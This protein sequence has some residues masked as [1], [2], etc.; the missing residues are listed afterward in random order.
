M[1]ALKQILNSLREKS[2][3]DKK[4]YGTSFEALC[5]DFFSYEPNFKAKF[6]EVLSY[7]E[8]AT[9]NN[10]PRKD[11]GI[12]LVAVN[13]DDDKFTAIQCKFYEEN[14]RIAKADIDS[15]LA[16]SST[17]DFSHRILIATCEINSNVKA[18][19]ESQAVPV[20]LLGRYDLENSGFDW[21]WYLDKLEPK[22][23]EPKQLRDYQKDA[24]AKVKAGLQNAERGKLIMAC[25]TGKTF[26]ALKI[27]EE[28]AGAGK[29]ILFLVPSLSLLDQTISEWQQNSAL[30]LNLW[31]VCSDSEVGKK[32]S[33]DD[34]LA[35]LSISELQYPAT[36]N[37]KQLAKDFALKHRAEKMA[38]IFSTY[39]SLEVIQEAQENF[40]LP[41][42]DLIIC[43]EA[44]RTTGY[45]WA[46]K[47]EVSIFSQ[48]TD[49]NFVKGKKRLFMT[50][51]PRVYKT[52]DN[53]KKKI[54][55]GEVKVFSMDDV[56]KYGKD[57]YVLPFSKAVEQK[58]LVDYKVIILAIKEDETLKELI[59]KLNRENSDNFELPA[60]DVSKIVGCWKALS[61]QAITGED[62]SKIMQR[63]VAF[64]QVID[65]QKSAKKNATGSKQI[66]DLFAKVVERY[67]SE[68]LNN[69]PIND[70]ICEVEHI[71]GTMNAY[72]KKEKIQWLKDEIP[73]NHCRILSNV[74]CLTEG[75]DVPALD[76][77]MFLTP[78]SSKVDIVQ[79]VGRVMRRA[80]GKEKG[81]VILPVVISENSDP[82]KVLDSNSYKV[83]WEVLNALRSHDDEFDALLNK[84]DLTKYGEKAPSEKIAIE[85]IAEAHIG[86]KV[87]RVGRVKKGDGD[88]IGKGDDKGTE[89]IKPVQKEF[90]FTLNTAQIIDAI[91][92]KI[93]KKCGNSK[94][95]EEWAEEV[96]VI[97]EKHISSI[98]KTL[99]NPA[100]TEQISAFS[101]FADNLKN[102][103][104]K[105]LT[106]DEIVQMLAQHI[107]TEPVFSALFAGSPFVENNPVSKA[108]KPVLEVLSVAT[109]IKDKQELEHFYS[110]VK[111]K[112]QGLQTLAAKQAL[113]KDL[114]DNFFNKAFS[115]MAE[116]LG[117]VYTPVEVVDFIIHSLEW[118]MNN[119]FNSSLKEKGVHILDPFTGTGT[120]ITRLLQSSIIP[121]EDLS[122]KY[123]NE[124]H[125]NEIVP[126]AY[127]IAAINIESV[128]H[129]LVKKEAEYQAFEGICLTDTFET[130]EDKSEF[131]DFGANLD[132]SDRISRQKKQEIRVIM[133]NPPY[134][135][136]QDSANDNT[137][138]NEYPALDKRI[139]ESYVA[140]TTATNKNSLYDSYIR[141]IRWATDRIGDKG[142]IGFITNGGW[143]DSNSADGLR[144]CLSEEF[145]KLY[146]FHL[147]GNQRTQGERSRQEGG[148]IFGSGS[149]API[150]ISILIKNPEIAERGKIYF[151]DIGDYLTR[152]EK[153]QI[154]SNFKSISGIT[155]QN[156]WLEI[157]PDKFNDWIN[158]RDPN[159]DNYISIGDKK[160]KNAISAFENYSGG[161]KT[162]RDAWCWNFSANTVAKNI[163]S[164]VDVYNAE[165]RLYEQMGANTSCKEFV[166]LDPTKI[167][168]CLS[169]EKQFEKLIRQVFNKNQIVL[170]LYRPFTKAYLYYSRELNDAVYQMPKI[171]PLN[172]N[173]ENEVFSLTGRGSTKEFSTL[174]TDEIPDLEMI[175]KGQCFPRYVYE[176]EQRTENRE[177][178]TE[179]REQRTERGLP[180]KRRNSK[181]QERN[182][183]IT[184]TIAGTKGFSCLITD[185]IPDLHLIGDSQ[186]FP[187]WI[188]Q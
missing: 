141:A 21:D 53:E 102:D 106:N 81:Y 154:I 10:L 188:W 176:L 80:E 184:T 165:L 32:K 109:D 95:W 187:M 129:D 12:D 146:I 91:Y 33:N 87:E 4:Q 40:N 30:D 149:R 114:Y 155:D 108:I 51:T 13:A 105:S 128:F 24:V 116:K 126:L 103:L 8:W 89:I 145:S 86:E 47:E 139:A 64:C 54:K 174:I 97:A 164:M 59:E 14:H 74:R 172:T 111:L 161:I 77:I 104:N 41:I 38:V 56:E 152:E 134:S 22:L 69:E 23:K 136:G 28:I 79:A 46:D 19:L 99:D 112:I 158:Q 147:R 115:K 58:L 93:L 113:I 121:L 29:T 96:S 127:Y 62:Y 162:N 160:D 123:K 173:L 18:Q 169:L 43:D 85:V 168:W 100:N 130:H 70:V 7:S 107:I 175:S 3:N 171:F 67:K 88:D 186:C 15:F 71:D 48:I 170:G 65:N 177:Q 131:K 31:A 27:A 1:S 157:I 26:T 183:V 11:T 63:S 20:Q 148:K 5:I 17:K 138:N 16:A 92:A 66:R 179:N 73:E 117:I 49:S 182:L 9:K 83:V 137:Q 135:A 180:S 110:R 150:V 61:K 44:H 151:H 25:G 42:F 122:H 125:A 120:F 50:A 143:L 84:I 156:G 90:D 166:N 45:A 167:S 72:A 142:V 2:A 36:T 144:Q 75:V 94:Q 185:C 57:L 163:G 159:F 153:L 34:D 181:S 35:I 78:K 6:K 39:H 52:D 98:K 37:A 60:S 101:A 76:A 133:G 124:I 68:Y 118:V 140:K 178:R 82:N 119:E 132:N 55:A